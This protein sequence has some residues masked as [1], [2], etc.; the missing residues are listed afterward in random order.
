MSKQRESYLI[1]LEANS[2]NVEALQQE[3]QLLKDVQEQR[4]IELNSLKEKIIESEKLTDQLKK[5]LEITLEHENT[6]LGEMKEILSRKE[7]Q[8]LEL[9]TEVNRLQQIVN[10]NKIGAYFEY[11]EL[12]LFYGYKFYINSIHYGTNIRH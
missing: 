5:N 6:T 10:V 3:N 8:V 1:S 9:Q 2:R 7:T 4:Q 11:K 12:K